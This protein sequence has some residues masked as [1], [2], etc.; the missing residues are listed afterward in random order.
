MFLINFS[1]SRPTNKAE[2]LSLSS[3]NYV[4]LISHI[5]QLPTELKETPFHPG[6]MNRNIRD[7]LAHLHEWQMMMIS[8]Y[9]VGMTGE[10]PDIPAKGFTWKTVPDLNRIIHQK[11]KKEQLQTIQSLLSESHKK[12]TELIEQH[13]DE[14]LFQKKRYHW[15][16]TTSLGAYFISA[17]SSHYDWALKLIKK[18]LKGQ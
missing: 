10:K 1:M 15:T 7:V 12:V 17:T 8:W 9:E 11:H 3:K 2:L 6:T 16:G 18:G 13:S 5:N 14:E 4:K